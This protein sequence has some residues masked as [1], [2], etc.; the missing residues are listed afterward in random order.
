MIRFTH[1]TAVVAGAILCGCAASKQADKKPGEA[2][3]DEAMHMPADSMSGK[4]PPSL[5]MTAAQIEHGG[6]KWGAAASSLVSQVAA[7]PGEIVPNEDRTARF[8]APAG[9]RILS[10]AVRPGDVVK[11]GQALV[12]MQSPEAGAAQ[13]DVAKAIAEESSRRA[14]VQYASSARARAARLLA[15]KAIP[16]QEYARFVSDDERARA[17]LAQAQAEVARARATAEQLSASANANGEIVLRATAPGVV[18]E[19]SALP[20][21]VVSAGT[22]LVVVTDPARLWLA[23][24]APEAT[25]GLFHRGATL[26]F[27]VP[28]FP[29]DTFSARIDAVGAGLEPETRTLSV[30]ADVERDPRIKPRMLATVLVAGAQS[31][32]RPLLPED[33]VQLLQGKPYVFIARTAEKGGAQFERRSVVPGP[34][35]NG[36][37]FIESGLTPGEVVV[38]AGAFAVKAEFE[39]STMSDME[40]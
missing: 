4:L 2:K 3:S 18:L 39:K 5:T 28:A 27:V 15:L 32:A 33:A 13:S 23:I 19:R 31:T 20:G 35:A 10:V 38:I 37:V 40:M 12:T 14:E 24:D 22:P 34:R 29:T 30:R 7:I 11:A 36:K 25:S 21:A 17:A 26:H 16:R 9:G 6:V 1:A 8:G